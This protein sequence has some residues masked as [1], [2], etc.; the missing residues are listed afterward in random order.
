MLRKRTGLCASSIDRRSYSASNLTS[1]HNSRTSQGTDL[2][3]QRGQIQGTLLFIDYG[4]RPQ[5][6]WLCRVPEAEEKGNT[7]H[8]KIAMT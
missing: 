8:L 3:Y 1:S 5:K 6:P 4:W 7:P 2:L